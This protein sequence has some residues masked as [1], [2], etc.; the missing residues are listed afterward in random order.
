[1]KD[2]HIKVNL[3]VFF[4]SLTVWLIIGGLVVVTMFDT[5]LD[6]PEPLLNLFMTLTG[7]VLTT[8]TG[9]TKGV[10]SNDKTDD[11]PHPIP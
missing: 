9:F 4:V 10:A 6:V 3:T 5:T 2:I 1:M 8:L 7:V 11:M